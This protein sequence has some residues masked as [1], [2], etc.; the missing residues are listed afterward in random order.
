[1]TNSTMRSEKRRHAEERVGGAE[2]HLEARPSLAALFIAF[3]QISMC[4]FGG[5]LV[6][7]RRKLV[8]QQQW[9]SDQEFAELLSFCQFLPGPNVVSLTVCVGAKFRGAAGALAALAGFVVIPWSIGFAV[10]AVLLSYVQ[11]ALLQHMLRGIAAAAAGLI[12]G[13]GVRLLSPYRRRPTALLFAV[14]AFAGLALAKL[15]LLTVV[16][17]LVPLSIVAARRERPAAAA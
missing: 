5:P 10:G 12:I 2:A 3:L 13:T 6:W 15:P 11:A 9:L 7:A 16:V 14:L 17:V 1:M 8:T 4:A